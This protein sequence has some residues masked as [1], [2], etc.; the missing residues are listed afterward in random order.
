MMKAAER[1]LIE[2]SDLSVE[3]I[4]EILDRAIFMSQQS[5]SIKSEGVRHVGLLFSEPSTRTVL[6]FRAAADRLGV[7]VLEL[8][9]GTSSLIKG[10]TISDTA[11]TLEA[12]G[13]AAIVVRDSQE[14]TARQLSQQCRAGIINAG[15][16]AKAHPSQ[17][18]LDAYTLVD[19]FGQLEGKRIGI[20][21]DILHS[22]VARSDLIAFRALGAEVVLV[23][24]PSLQDE[25]L[26]QA[27]VVTRSD[28]DEV[29]PD[30]DAI[31]MLRIQH[32]RMDEGCFGSLDDY[33]ASYQLNLHRLE[34]ARDSL[35]VMHPG[36]MNRGIEITDEVADSE[37]S[38]I[39]AQVSAGVSV[40][41]ALLE[42]ALGGLAG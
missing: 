11:R 18:L 9:P 12:M 38:R 22:R 23:A 16:G 40:R 13:A 15:G 35:V 36:P 27:G 37:R 32:E 8:Q 33:I 30:L 20:V 42:R 34:R 41:M 26:E 19:E 39:F 7:D 25:S 4:R 10:E 5:D 31:Q 21:G 17:G 6:S 2:L 14:Q 1:D 29:L 24:P 3:S 28:L